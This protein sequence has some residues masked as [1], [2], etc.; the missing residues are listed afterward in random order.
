MG[1][2]PGLGGAGPQ[3]GSL[4]IALERGSALLSVTPHL[5]PVTPATPLSPVSVTVTSMSR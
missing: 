3:Q 2:A 4:G 1:P 5:A